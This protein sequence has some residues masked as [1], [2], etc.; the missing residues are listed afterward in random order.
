MQN[1]HKLLYG[2]LANQLFINSPYHDEDFQLLVTSKDKSDAGFDYV[3]WAAIATVARND[4]SINS[5]YHRQDLQTIVKYGS[6]SLQLSNLAVH[7]VSLKDIY[8]LEN[9]EI[10]A[11]N[12]EIGNF[13]Y[14]VMTHPQAIKKKNYRSI[15]REMVENKNNIGYVFLVCYY[16]IGEQAEVEAQNILGHNY[17]YKIKSSYNI[18]EL[19]KK[20]DERINVIDGEFKDVTI[21]EIG[22]DNSE[23]DNQDLSNKNQKKIRRF[24]RKNKSL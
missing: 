20:V 17:L 4:D 15:I 6:K 19:L 21:Y 23:C 1:V 8:H 18:T 12:Q 10:L 3:L 24:F 5:E 7:P 9:M 14:A 22:C 11:Q 13:L 2:L 16:A